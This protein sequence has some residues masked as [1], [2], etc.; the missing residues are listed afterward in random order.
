MVPHAGSAVAAAELQRP[1]L[2]G[3]QELRSY[4]GP[5]LEQLQTESSLIHIPYLGALLFETTPQGAIGRAQRWSPSLSCW[6]P[7]THRVE[8]EINS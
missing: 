5:Y 8:G 6:I 3:T 2:V 1:A 7:G 4:L